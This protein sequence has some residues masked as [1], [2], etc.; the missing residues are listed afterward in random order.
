[1]SGVVL[2][3]APKTVVELEGS[4]VI[5]FGGTNYFGLSYEDEVILAAQEGLIKWG[6]SS[7]GSRETTG[8]AKVHLELENRLCEFLER[9]NVVTCCSGYMVNLILLQALSGEYDVCLLDQNAHCSVKNAVTGAAMPLATFENDN[10]KDL[11]SRLKQCQT[12]GKK[13]LICTDG[14]YASGALAPLGSYQE[15]AAKWNAAIVVDDAHGVGVLGKKGKGTLEQLGLPSD[16]VFQ[17]GTLSKAFGCF[18]GFGAG[19]EPLSQLVSTRSEAYVGSTPLPAAIASAAI[20]SIDIVSNNSDLR[21]SLNR[22][23]KLL[24]SGLSSLGISIEDSPAPIAMF[25]LGTR[26]YNRK[27]HRKLL[28]KKILVPYNFYPGGP[29]DGFFRMVVTA[30]HSPD[31]IRRVLETLGNLLS[32]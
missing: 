5:Y 14:V 1:M 15:L 28:E 10:I 21:K 6:I 30:R 4:P 19:D 27:I 8:S 17:T 7:A 31:Q 25:V 32:E 13:A 9:D 12:E 26:D 20:A 18:G 16:Y 3:G 29:K 22:N 11:E 23:T 24:K 2:H